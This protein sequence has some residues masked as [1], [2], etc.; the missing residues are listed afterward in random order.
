[1]PMYYMHLARYLVK[2]VLCIIIKVRIILR[3]F[4][5]CGLNALLFGK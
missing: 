2:C 1:M 5:E 4:F 3:V